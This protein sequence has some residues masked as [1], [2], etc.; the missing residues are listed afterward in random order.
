MGK[1]TIAEFVGDQKS[2]DV[3]RRLG[4]DYGQGYF[5]GHPEPLADHLAAGPI[6]NG[7]QQNERAATVSVDASPLQ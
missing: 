6:P 2:V 1:R 7:R 3:L 5:L 4:V